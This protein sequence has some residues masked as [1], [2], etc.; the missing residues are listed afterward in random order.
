[1]QEMKINH[2]VGSLLRRK[3]SFY[4]LT[5]DWHSR[6]LRLLHS[7]EEYLEELANLR[8]M[9]LC[10]RYEGTISHQFVL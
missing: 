3:Q 8:D 1:M 6:C 7:S 10:K 9:G 5:F 2:K 4:A